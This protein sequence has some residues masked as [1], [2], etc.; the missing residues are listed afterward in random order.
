M[1]RDITGDP[2]DRGRHAAGARFV[3]VAAGYGTEAIVPA[4]LNSGPPR[5]EPEE[6]WTLGVGHHPERPAEGGED[7]AVV[8]GDPSAVDPT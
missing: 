6:R 8:A 2:K 7:A 5:P 3:P 4:P 1:A